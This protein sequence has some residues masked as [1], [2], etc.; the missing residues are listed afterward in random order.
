MTSLCS[1]MGTR[2][3]STTLYRS[4]TR[5]I[6]LYPLPTPPVK[7]LPIFYFLD[8]TI[9]KSSSFK[10]SG[11]LSYKPFSKPTNHHLYVH[12]QSH[13]PVAT[14]KS[15]IRGE[16]IRLMRSCSDENVFQSFLIS[17]SSSLFVIEAIQTLSPILPCKT[18]LIS[19][20]GM[21]KQQ[22]SLTPTPPCSSSKHF[23]ITQTATNKRAY[24]C[25]L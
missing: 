2:A 11:V 9:Y 23:L 20:T 21:T 22:K 1:G 14:K 6:P 8:L 5:H 16:T 19:N 25:Q 24:P 10:T 15:I 7:S 12:S 3:Q 17:N 13:H 18:Y 4:S